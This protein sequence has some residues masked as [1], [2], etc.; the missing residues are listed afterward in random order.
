MP[1]QPLQVKCVNMFLLAE[2]ARYM[3]VSTTTFERVFLIQNVVKT[4]Q[5]NRLGTKHLDVVLRVAL[6]G[7][8]DDYDYILVE[9]IELWRNS[10]NGGNYTHL[11]KHLVG[12]SS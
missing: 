8:Q 11:E 2:I 4:K 12:H 10:A 6:E 5:M 3:C 9:A 1:L 7:P